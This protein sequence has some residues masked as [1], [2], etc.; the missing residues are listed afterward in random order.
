MDH[1]HIAKVLDGGLT[2]DK[3][4]FFIMEL[5]NGLPLTKF[6]D[7]ANL[8][9]PDRLA[10]FIP[11]CQAVQH[12]HQKG[13]I[14]RDLKPSNILVTFV[15]GKPI[16]KIIDFGVAKAIGEK[17]VDS[18]MTTQ[19]GTIV[20]TL[21]YMAPEQAGLSGNDIDTRAD[22]YSLGVILYELLTGL[23]PFDPNRLKQATLDEIIRMLRE[24]EPSKP[25]TRLSI[26]QSLPSRAATRQ[27]DPTKLTKLLRGELD[28]VVMK[29]LEKQRS[30]RYETA[31]SLARDIQRYLGNEPVEARPPN[32]GYRLRKF[33]S[34]NKVQVVAASLVVFV[35]LLG[36]V[37]TT[38]GL[39]RA[40]Q[41]AK[42]ER[43]AKLDADAKRLEAET[44]KQ[45]ANEFRDKAL[46]ILRPTIAEDIWMLVGDKGELEPNT[47]KYLETIADRWLVFA[48]LDGTD[49]KTRSI[50]AEGSFRVAS[51]WYLLGRFNDA[52][53]EY[54]KAISICK[55]LI[56]QFPDN[57]RY[58]Q[59]LA[60][61]HNNL[62]MMLDAEGKKEEARREFEKAHKLLEKLTKEFPQV[63]I[64]QLDLGD[65]YC[66]L[67]DS[68][69]ASG[70]ST[71]RLDWFGKAIQTLTA[72]HDQNPQELMV[73]QILLKSLSNRVATLLKLE[74]HAET[75]KDYDKMIEL[76]T[77]VQQGIFRHRRAL[78]LLRINRTEEAVEEVVQLLK[79]Y[80]WDRNGLYDFSCIYAV[81][82]SKIPQKKEEYQN[83]AMELLQRAVRQGWKDVDH[84]MKDGDL[85]SLRDRDD[86]K[87]LLESLIKAKE[88]QDQKKEIPKN[89][90]PSS[91]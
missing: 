77:K 9:I 74:K 53:M 69:Q 18:S 36:I 68:L 21:E 38:W 48:R 66:N 44:E 91:K 73:Q 41:S 79:S 63:P 57:P 30:R 80:Y 84:M 33:V 85:D 50:Q 1:P 62:A 78:S 90:S 87:K 52:W 42:A 5:V 67:G 35:L 6:C 19:F 11:I 47:K 12:A 13:I 26:E 88:I 3:R 15:D 70:Q 51:F 58:Q 86:F 89:S 29:C 61:V 14:H 22:I 4:P 7:E 81:A 37:G 32:T 64:Y 65:S 16:P 82:S 31:D 39:I 76:G 8:A 10:L 54:E 71:E 56:E 28:W 40:E 17:L 49:E 43:E 45:R 27:I 72:V 75:I 60:R 34:R 83:L 23:V 55:E 59:D 24:E 2:E 25:S 46:E 20:G